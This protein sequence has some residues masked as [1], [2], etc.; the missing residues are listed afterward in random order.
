PIVATEMRHDSTLIFLG[1]DNIGFEFDTFYDRRNGFF[2]AVNAVGGRNEGQS[3]NDRQFVGDWNGVWE[4]RVGR[5]EGGWTL[6]TAIPF[7]T[8]RYRPG[9]A[10]IWGF[11]VH[12][13][14]YG[15]NERSYLSP[16]PAARGEGGIIA[17]SLAATVIG[18][19]APPGSKNVE[20]KPYATSNI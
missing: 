19:E 2:F 13:K 3:F 20:F 1:N 9:R 11:N 8:L 10:Q 15:R 12:R 14:S 16:I 18:L 6:E 17:M 5:F 7:K 4:S